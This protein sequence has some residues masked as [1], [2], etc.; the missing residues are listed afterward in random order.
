MTAG[1]IERKLTTILVADVVGLSRA[2]P[3]LTRRERLRG[4]ERSAA[5]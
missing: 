2:S 1:E 4:S 3:P 5:I